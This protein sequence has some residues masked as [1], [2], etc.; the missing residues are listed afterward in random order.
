MHTG[1]F[2]NRIGIALAEDIRGQTDGQKFHVCVRLTP[3]RH[4]YLAE[5]VD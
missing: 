4:N 3:A 5:I 2:P 1:H